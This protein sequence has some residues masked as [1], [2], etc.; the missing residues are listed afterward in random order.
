MLHVSDTVK[1]KISKLS[2][3]PTTQF[4]SCIFK[5][6]SIFKQFNFRGNFNLNDF[7]VT[8][9]KN[10]SK[11]CLSLTYRNA[12]K[13]FCLRFKG[14]DTFLSCISI[15]ITYST[16]NFIQDNP[17]NLIPLIS[18]VNVFTYTEKGGSVKSSK[19]NF[20]F[21]HAFNFHNL[22]SI[23]FRNPHSFYL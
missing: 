10:V 18:S 5:T 13:L 23:S 20:R 19:Q 15:L 7:I 8:L 22:I 6:K 3:T 16:R 9:D 4:T 11:M 1:P 14:N 17:Y 12:I 21:I 2:Y